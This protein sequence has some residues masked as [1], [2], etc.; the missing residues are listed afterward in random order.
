MH[1]SYVQTFIFLQQME[2]INNHHSRVAKI[3]LKQKRLF[4][5]VQ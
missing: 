4:L 3:S 5:Q 1:K 2:E